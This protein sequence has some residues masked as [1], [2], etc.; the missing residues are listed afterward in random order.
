[1]DL[2]LKHAAMNNLKIVQR[3]IAGQRLSGNQTL[4]QRALLRALFALFLSLQPLV[5]LRA[6]ADT[7]GRWSAVL[8]RFVREDTP[9]DKPRLLLYPTFA[10]APE[11]SLELGVASALLFHAKN[12]VDKNRLSEITAFAFF[13][14]RSQYGLWLD[15]AVYTDRDRWL[16]LGK[17]RFQRF[18]LLY[19]GIGPDTP[20]D[21]PDVVDG[22]GVLVRQRV[23]H[24][25]KGNF[26][27]GLQV[28]YQRLSDVQFGENG[29]SQR[30][31]PPGAAGSQS[32]GLGLGVAY[33]S[34]P[35]ALNTRNGLFAEFGWLRYDPA[36]AGDFE[37]ENFHTDIRW[38]KSY[39]PQQVLAL[40]AVGSI[41]L[42]TAPFH[43]M[44]LLGSEMIM[45]G[46]YTGRYRDQH[47][48][49]AQAEYRWLPLP[50]SRRL[51]AT[52]FLSAGGVAPDF[53]AMRLSDLRLAGGFGARYY[54]FPKKDIFLRFD[55][56]FTREGSG[57]YIFTGEAF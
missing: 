51:G 54:L 17:A 9:A 4:N 41:V 29:V 43:Q 3:L 14:F 15:N 30:P 11:T 49:A 46:Y 57:F 23:F 45:R 10:F 21:N 53:G 48:Y 38:Y 34:R 2:L 5:L 25:I 35:N 6:Q 22:F 52:A 1:M 36:L 19:Y 18:P 44:S 24:Q 55:L 20:K 16:L 50:F 40:Q 33:D 39:R 26:F 56:A 31:L 13:T 47:Y 37:F 7:L 28:D 27:A 12:E 32:L 8:E 42:G